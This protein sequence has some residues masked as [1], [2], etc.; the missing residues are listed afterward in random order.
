MSAAVVVFALEFEGVVVAV[1]VE[2]VMKAF[3]S[4]AAAARSPT[5]AVAVETE[6]IVAHPQTVDWV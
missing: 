2:I 4:V 3:P 1:V 6:R 5:V